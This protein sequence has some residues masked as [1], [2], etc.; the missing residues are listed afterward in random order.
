MA[1]AAA[2][3][4]ETATPS[5]AGQSPTTVPSPAIADPTG[6]ITMGGGALGGN[7]ETVLL[8]Q[9]VLHELSNA[10]LVWAAYETR[11]EAGEMVSHSHEFAFVY[12]LSGRHLFNQGMA[13]RSMEPSQGEVVSP[14][15]AHR[16]GAIEGVS[17]YWEVMLTAPGSGPPPNSAGA[18]LVFESGTLQDIPDAPLATFVIV[19]VPPGGETS[20]H[21]HPGPELIY[22]LSGR[23]NY[24]NALIGV[25]QLGPGGVEGIP[26]NTAVQKRNP[27]DEEAA[28][29]SWFLVDTAQPFA[30]AARFE[31]PDV[32][33]N[34]LALAE[35]GASVVGVS[36]NFGGGNIDSA[37]GASNALDGDTSTEWSS[38]GDGDGAWIEIALATKTNVTSL[39]FWTRT[40]GTS[41]QISSF[42]VVTDLGRTIGPFTVDSAGTVSF[43]ETDFEATRL[44]FEVI[45][46][47]GGNTGAIEIEVYGVP[48]P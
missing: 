10:D 13:S 11:L 44:R 37:Y 14:N 46:S 3:T 6:A 21:T 7:A 19:K 45:E 32:E 39:G 26:P 41:A 35:R 18:R 24:E 47:S 15:I 4:S 43:F 16:H 25:R 30:S 20:V 28:F 42:Q 2:A 27:F 1:A 36:S 8:G 17:I 29:L 5:T 22:Q 12:A 23:I 31:S 38:D 40:M 34:N 33:G 9:Q 48:V